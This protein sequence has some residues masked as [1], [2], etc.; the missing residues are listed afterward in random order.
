MMTSELLGSAMQK[1]KVQGIRVESGIGSQVAI[2]EEVGRLVERGREVR[3]DP[4][5][6][7]LVL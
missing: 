7:R 1:Q 5:R 2:L 6:T 3:E 4:S